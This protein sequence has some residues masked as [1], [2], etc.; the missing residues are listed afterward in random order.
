MKS[1]LLIAIAALLVAIPAL[2][3]PLDAT[4]T[5]TVW[6]VYETSTGE[7]RRDTMT[8][9]LAIRDGETTEGGIGS[10]S[11]RPANSYKWSRIDSQWAEW[12]GDH[13]EL[14]SIGDG[15]GAITEGF[16]T[17][18]AFLQSALGGTWATTR[19]GTCTGDFR[20]SGRD[21]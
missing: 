12:I 10:G 6:T 13:G 7:T 19:V 14:L 20:K 18:N 17:Y 1:K 8:Q 9:H 21:E 16:G 4:C 3:Q 5:F 2:A 11:N 15:G